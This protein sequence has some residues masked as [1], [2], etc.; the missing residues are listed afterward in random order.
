MLSFLMPVIENLKTES[1]KKAITQMIL[2]G[3]IATLL[4][5]FFDVHNNINT[6]YIDFFVAFFL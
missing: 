6:I 1:K 3:L 4:A 2:I 5:V